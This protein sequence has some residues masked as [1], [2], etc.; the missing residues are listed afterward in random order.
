[1]YIKFMNADGTFAKLDHGDIHDMYSVFFTNRDN[2][3][4]FG[5]T[6]AVFKI[7]KKVFA[8]IANLKTHPRFRKQGLAKTFIGHLQKF[9]LLYIQ[10]KNREACIIASTS[11]A[12]KSRLFF[13]RV[14][15]KFTDIPSVIR[16]WEMDGCEL[17]MFNVESAHY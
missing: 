10:G 16:V 7:G 12:L 14:G 8:Y 4:I 11:C 5:V 13:E 9:L 15:F 17:C 1:M 3:V 2:T 6:F